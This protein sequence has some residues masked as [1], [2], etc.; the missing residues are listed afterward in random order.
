MK[1]VNNLSKYLIIDTETTNDLEC[2]IVY[3]IGFA[4]I[5]ELGL[6]YERGS[7]VVA[8]VFLDKDLM[9]SA[10][11]ADKI[12][13]YQAEINN[14]TRK[15]RRWKTIRNIIKDVMAQ[16]NTTNVVA[17]NM[18]FDYLST[19]TTQRYLTSSRYRW[20]FPY[21]TR[22]FDTL[23]MAREVFSKDQAYI[24]FCH[25][26]EYLCKNGTPR[27]TAEILYRY[28]TK[29]NFEERHMAMEDVMI[30]K[31]IFAECFRRNPNINGELWQ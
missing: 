3:D 31:E 2:P 1:G 25:K 14:G 4:I 11:F 26:H 17:H 16:W 6:V 21:G 12:P 13:T 30:E 8:D 24:D 10:F 20:F 18:R 5:D 9:A 22:Y 23:K 29:S 7:Y 28:L 19:H 27:Y 15:L